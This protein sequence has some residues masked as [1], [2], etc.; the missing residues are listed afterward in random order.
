MFCNF[1]SNDKAEESISLQLNI[2]LISDGITFP[3]N[4]L[5][6]KKIKL[7]D[8]ECETCTWKAIFMQRYNNYLWNLS[9]S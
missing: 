3:A 2:Q 8:K 7:R 4:L 1:V 6:K 5:Y 9:T